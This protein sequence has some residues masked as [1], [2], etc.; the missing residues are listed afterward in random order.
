MTKIIK[1][2]GREVD[3]NKD[4]IVQALLKAMSRC[5]VQD[6]EE[7]IKIS[8]KIEEKVLK[9]KDKINVETI[10]NEVELALMTSKY[11]KV[12]KEYITH[13]N[14]RTR[15][16]DKNNNLNEKIKDVLFCRNVQNQN[17]NVDEYSFGGRKNES[18]NILHKELALSAFIREEV[19][20][21]HKENRIYL[22]DL[23]EY[24][25]GEHN[26]LFIDMQNLLNN[27]FCTRNGDVRGANS[28]NT[29]C[30]LIA[31]IFQIQSQNQFGGV[32]SA[33]IDF[34]LAPFVKKSFAKKLK[35]VWNILDLT[36][37][38]EGFPNEISV[39]DI[40]WQ[41]RS[42]VVVF[43]KALKLLEKEGM[44]ST[45]GLFHNL[46]T[47]ESRAGSQVPFTSINYGRDA[48]PEGKLVSKWLLQASLDGIGKQHLTS[49]FPISIFMHKK[50][51]NDKEGTPNY[52][53]KK[54]AIK[55]LSKRIYPNIVNCDFSQ[56]IE[57]EKD[58]DTMMATMGCRT[59]IGKDRH[60]L[61]YKKVGR[62]NVCPVTINLPKL[63]IN[64]GICL[65]ERKK[66]D[67][68]GFWRE[69]EEVLKLSETALVDRFY[70]ICNQSVKSA[71]FMYQNGSIADYEK[72][73]LKGIYEAMKHSTLAIGYIGIAEMCQALFGKD[74]SEGEYVKEFALSVVKHIWDYAQEASERNDLN[75]GCY[76]TPA[77]NLCKTYAKALQEEFGSIPKVTDRDY[78]TNSHHI[79]VWQE[80]SIYK[81]L[82]TEAPF[83]KY[84][85]AGCITYIE[86]ESKI[87]DNP[88]AIEDII[89]YAMD[90][91]IPY[92]AFNFPID[93]CLKCGFQGEIEYNCPK[94]GNTNIQRLRR[95]TGYLT[96]DYRNFNEGKVKEC[97]D[98][99]KHSKYTSFTG[100]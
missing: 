93:T 24:T 8:C 98:R 12:A 5:D 3:F 96:T 23:S 28:F 49:I 30:Q 54:L 92:L 47:L 31:V 7:A 62:G 61:G 13:R 40:Y 17:A 69:F 4:K 38:K 75:F 26:C 74:H 21:A 72:A 53:I 33:H 87:M 100:N 85:T 48:S 99:V 25:I 81:K 51:V 22:H 35:E 27:G 18:A 42:G 14:E 10:Q 77:E 16:R 63:G 76:A 64:H 70:H 2:D 55:S 71:T 82:E 9:A 15:N 6:E 50:G 59:M 57:D 67:I 58:I 29:A 20:Q 46:N 68:D 37:P 60:G 95:V 86:L 66:A 97:L 84:P 78:I 56:N 19:A 39:D 34:D 94:C 89:D 73:Q 79:P 83:C 45:Q 41:E 32:A 88:Q 11:K 91:D 90:L 44:Q 1:R 43:D 52:D 65:G 80:V 36:P